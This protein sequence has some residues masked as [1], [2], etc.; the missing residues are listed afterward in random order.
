M[1]SLNETITLSFMVVGHTKF[2]PDSCFGLIKQRFR[3]THVQCLSDIAAV[4]SESAIVNEVRLVRTEAGEVFVPTYN[5]ISFFAPHFKK[6]SQIKQFHQFH[7]RSSSPGTIECREFSDT[8]TITVSLL[9]DAWQPAAT[10]LPPTISPSGLSSER[11]WYL[12]DKI[13]P[14]CEDKYQDITCPQPPIP[15]P[16]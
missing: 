9:K 6:V 3:R 12:F 16:Q 8:S 15:R 4:V 5:W 11:Q 13:R 2:T 10:D 7:I 14:F 1:A